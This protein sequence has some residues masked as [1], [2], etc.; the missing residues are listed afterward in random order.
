LTSSCP[1]SNLEHKE[2]AMKTVVTFSDDQIRA[3]RERAAD[4]WMEQLSEDTPEGWSISPIDLGPFVEVFAPLRVK[5]GWILRAYQFRQGRNGNAVVW[6]MPETL[7]FPRPEECPAQDP[8]RPTGALDDVMEAI[9]GDG[10]PE[11]FLHAALF[12]REAAEI[13]AAGHGAHWDAFQILTSDPWANDD[14]TDYTSPYDGPTGALAEWEWT[15]PRPV[16]WRPTVQVSDK[17]ITVKFYTFCGVGEQRI[18]R[19]VDTFRTGAGQYRPA[20]EETV[21]ARGPGGYVW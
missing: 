20:T 12:A 11:S 21:I 8:P 3:L 16:D 14:Q 7:P 5:P 10:S 13:G 4:A 17:I 6:A 18:T 19:H 15:E 9:E 2:L 1:T